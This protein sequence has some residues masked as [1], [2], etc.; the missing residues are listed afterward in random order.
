[1]HTIHLN[2]TATAADLIRAARITDD[3]RRQAA[4]R[5]QARNIPGDLDANH[6]DAL[7]DQFPGA[8]GKIRAAATR[9]GRR[10]GAY[11]C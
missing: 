1:M 4:R 7:I 6:I 5:R 9:A 3:D 11:L 2:T 10:A 8:S